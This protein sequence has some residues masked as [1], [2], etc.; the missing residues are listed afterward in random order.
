MIA[1]DKQRLS[2]TCSPVDDI[3]DKQHIGE[4]G[5]QHPVHRCFYLW[6]NHNQCH[7]D[8]YQQKYRNGN[9]FRRFPQQLL[10]S[11][12]KQFVE[13]LKSLSAACYPRIITDT[14]AA[15]LLRGLLHRILVRENICLCQ[16]FL[17]HSAVAFERPYFTQ[18]NYTRYYAKTHNGG[19]NDFRKHPSKHRKPVSRRQQHEKR[20]DPCPIKPFNI[21]LVLYL[22][23]FLVIPQRFRRCSD[24]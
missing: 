23:V 13:I 12:D 20:C 21:I 19:G 15:L 24:F 4:Q 17:I 9:P 1:V 16:Q 6:K 18:E 8:R 3:H 22:A 7:Y 14:A 11:P 5:Q 10:M 2:K